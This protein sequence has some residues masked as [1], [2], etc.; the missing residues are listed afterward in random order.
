MLRKHEK[1][2]PSWLVQLASEQRPEEEELLQALKRCT[3]K[4]G[5]C[6]CGCGDP[7][8]VDPHSAEWKPAYHIELQRA[9]GV[10]V[11]VTILCDGRVGSVEV[12]EWEKKT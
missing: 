3:S 10:P 1:Y 5:E 4:V 6:E 7:F 12:G 11:I 2:D 9:D 8:F